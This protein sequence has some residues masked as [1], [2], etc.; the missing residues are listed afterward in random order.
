LYEL[1]TNTDKSF[2]GAVAAQEK[3][4][5]N[6]LDHL[7]KRLLKA[8]KRKLKSENEVVLNIQKMLFPKQSLQERYLNFSEIYIDYGARLI[9]KLIEELDPFQTE[10]LCLELTIYNKKH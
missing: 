5:K 2:Y 3:K 1:A 8:Q 6:G 10:F 7:E 4:Q 9:P